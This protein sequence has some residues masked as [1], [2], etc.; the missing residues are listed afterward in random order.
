MALDQALQEQMGRDA[1]EHRLD[2][3]PPVLAFQSVMDSTV[4]TRA[5]V[6]GL[7]DQLPANGSELV[8]F[9]INQAASFRPLFKPSSWAAT[10]E[11]LPVTKR[12]YGVTII[13]NASA[14]SFAAVAKIT[15]A[16]GTDE[17][18]VPLA[19]SGRRRS[20][21]CRMSPC[22][23]RLMTIFMADILRRKTGMA[24]ASARLRCGGNLRA[25]RRQ[26]RVNAGDV[27]PV[28]C[29]HAGED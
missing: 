12:R 3:L 16:G 9:D 20:I 2:Q 19:M 25:E 8:V 6:T 18:A 13:T 21:H 14:D 15:P 5:V 1:R 23:S 27:E 29:L 22:R 26:R 7:F 10:S 17:T 4:S 24:L 11:L 28:L